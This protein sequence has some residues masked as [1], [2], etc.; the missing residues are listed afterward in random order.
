MCYYFGSK[1]ID[2]SRIIVPALSSIFGIGNARAKYVC[3]LAGLDTSLR[4]RDLSMFYFYMLTYFIKYY[5]STEMSLVRKRAN[6]RKSFLSLKSHLSTKFNAG[7]PLRGQRTH[8]NAKTRK[9][10]VKKK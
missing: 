8:N 10:S 6:R 3:A 2:D 9:K 7:L 1:V 5:Y 4:V